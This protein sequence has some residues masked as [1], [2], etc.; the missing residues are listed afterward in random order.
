MPPPMM[1]R[2][3]RLVGRGGRAPVCGAGCAGR[4][5]VAR[6]ISRPV[7]SAACRRMTRT[8]SSIDRPCRA[9]RSRSSCLELV[10]ELADGETGHRRFL[11]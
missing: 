8:S 1:R 7:S 4:L 2:T 10:V 5:E 11:A 3:R 9:A 6:A